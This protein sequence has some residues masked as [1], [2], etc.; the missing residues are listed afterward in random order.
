MTLSDMDPNFWN[1]GTFESTYHVLCWTTLVENE[2]VQSEFRQWMSDGLTFDLRPSPQYNTL[3]RPRRQ[4]E[5][6]EVD[7]AEELFKFSV[8]SWEENEHVARAPAGPVD[9]VGRLQS[10][11]SLLKPS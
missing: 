3:T 5:P 1:S 8:T 2:P 10:S 4:D 11:S 6:M 9:F 7:L